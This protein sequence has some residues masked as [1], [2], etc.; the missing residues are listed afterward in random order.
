MD[1]RGW[2]NTYKAWAMIARYFTGFAVVLPLWTT[3]L[4][5]W[6]S[7]TIRF[8]W[9]PL[10]FLFGGV[11]ALALVIFMSAQWFLRFCKRKRTAIL[12]GIAGRTGEKP[13]SVG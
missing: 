13:Y 2:A 8:G 11:T 10:T 6:M 5:W 3:L 9:Q 4:T 1:D 7:K 12:E